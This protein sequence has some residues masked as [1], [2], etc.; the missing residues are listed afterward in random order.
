VIQG[1]IPFALTPGQA[2]QNK[3]L[4]F[5]I[6]HHRTVHDKTIASLFAEVKDRFNLEPSKVQPLLVSIKARSRAIG[7]A[8]LDIPPT[9][10]DIPGWTNARHICDTHGL[11]PLEH[12]TEV[13]TSFQGATAEVQG[14]RLQD[15]IA[16]TLMLRN[17]L[18]QEAQQ[19]LVAEAKDYTINNVESGIL[20]FKVILRESMGDASV[21]PSVI[22]TQLS[23]LRAKFKELGFDIRKL[24][25]FAFNGISE[26]A[27]SGQVSTDIKTHLVNANL[28]HPDERVTDYVTALEDKQKDSIMP[29]IG[30][31]CLMQLFKHK[32]NHIK[33]VDAN[34]KTKLDNKIMA[35]QAEVKAVGQCFNKF[36]KEHKGDKPKDAKKGAKPAPVQGNG[37]KKGK[38]DKNK[39]N[40]NKSLRN[41]RP[42]V[43]LLTRGKG[44]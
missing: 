38:K 28:S 4:D 6:K 40:P 34:K 20:L 32:G 13:A 39:P 33:Q 41:L 36:A 31:S 43:L 22:R 15:D 12:L 10:V 5:R 26:L 30:Y 17:S 42:S 2:V 25:D 35:L 1:P 27:Q 8:T 3:L 24:N 21:D 16:F 14:M 23:E 18:T 29:E 7:M 44:F 19:F 11:L 37:K 9:Q